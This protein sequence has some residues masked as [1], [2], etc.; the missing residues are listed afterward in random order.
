MT[1][2]H[3]LINGLD[4]WQQ[5]KEKTFKWAELTTTPGIPKIA[6]NQNWIIKIIWIIFL[7]ASTVYCSILIINSFIAYLEFKVNTV[8]SF[9]KELHLQFPT[10]SFCNL[11]LFNSSHSDLE[12]LNRI[13]NAKQKIFERLNFTDPYFIT[14]LLGYD[15]IQI[16]ENNNRTKEI[17]QSYYIDDMLLSC[18]FGFDRCDSNDFEYFYSPFME[19]ATNSTLD[20]IEIRLNLP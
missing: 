7:A 12:V 9:K 1:S 2:D 19:I 6:H 17:E 8:V 13:E 16:F 15:I 18:S 10:I 3:W 4:M 5:I 20:F 11:N 14:L